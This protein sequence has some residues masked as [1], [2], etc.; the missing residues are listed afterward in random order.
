M[1]VY[2][3]TM[4]GFIFVI[5]LYIITHLMINPPS[6][7]WSRM[8]KGFQTDHPLF[9]PYVGIGIKTVFYFLKKLF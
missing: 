9:V 6:E 8:L 4:I 3:Y 5:I 2:K 1:G 7:I